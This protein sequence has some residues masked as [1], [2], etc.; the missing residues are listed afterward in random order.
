[1]YIF[2]GIKR[3]VYR[4]NCFIWIK[5]NRL[6]VFFV[7]KFEKIDGSVSYFNFLGKELWRIYED[8]KCI[9]FLIFGYFIEIKLIVFDNIGIKMFFVILFVKFKFG[10]KF[11]VYYG[12]VD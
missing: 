3:N 7:E 5:L 2:I 9:G 10:Y 8:L 4:N 6:L 1:M 11:S 12:M